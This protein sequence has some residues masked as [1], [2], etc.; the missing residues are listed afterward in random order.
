M[1]IGAGAAGLAAAAELNRNGVGCLILEARARVGGRILTVQPGGLDTDFPMELGAEFVHGVPPESSRLI[2]EFDLKTEELPGKHEFLENG[3]LKGLDGFWSHLESAMRADV[4]GVE[5]ISFA[6]HLRAMGLSTREAGLA[7]SYIEGFHAASPELM[8]QRALGEETRE[9]EKIEGMKA[10][11]LRAGYGALTDALRG[12]LQKDR[13]ALF[14]GSPVKKVFWERGHIQVWTDTGPGGHRSFEGKALIVT[15]PP[16]A[17]ERIEFQP[18]LREKARALSGIISGPV[19]KVLVTF[20]EPFWEQILGRDAGFIHSRERHF[21][22]WW[23]AAP[24]KR[25]ML[26]GW[27]GGPVALE[28]SDQNEVELRDQAAA[29][30]A[31][32]LRL[33]RKSVLDLIQGF[34]WHDWQADPYSEGAYSYL[35]VGASEAPLALAVPLRGTLFFAGEATEKGG[36]GGTVEAALQSGSRAAREVLKGLGGSR[37]LIEGLGPREL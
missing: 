27:T 30:L 26:T 32:M 7:R 36:V 19:V 15:A 25:P 12:S 28:L 1:I 14:L 9:S 18:G 4:D 34:H 23:T 13:S 3:L 2:R 10:T 6:T 29:S 8:S 11:R 5:D 33:S 16:R 17:L 24:E 20:H 22:T 37:R 31:R 21:P 35:R